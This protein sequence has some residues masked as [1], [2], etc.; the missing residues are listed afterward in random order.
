MGSAKPVLRPARD[1]ENPAQST[2]SVALVDEGVIP[3]G[4]GSGDV[5]YDD[6]AAESCGEGAREGAREEA[7]DGARVDKNVVDGGGGGAIGYN[8]PPRR[9]AAARDE[10]E[11][12]GGGLTAAGVCC[13]SASTPSPHDEGVSSCAMSTRR[14]VSA[15]RMKREYTHT[16]YASPAD[17]G[18][19]VITRPMKAGV[20]CSS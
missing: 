13:S 17:S 12:G 18:A 10:D 6:G 15:S 16:P 8:G 9:D 2:K 3:V 11:E 19:F 5:A 20:S 1:D 4:A 14:R 7:R